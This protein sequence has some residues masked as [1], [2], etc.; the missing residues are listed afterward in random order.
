MTMSS[1]SAIRVADHCAG[2]VTQDVGT[3][4]GVVGVADVLVV[5]DG[6]VVDAG[7]ADVVVEVVG[8]PDPPVD[9]AQP[10]RTAP[11]M[12]RASPAAHT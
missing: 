5:E 10:D 9:P 4:V 11:A 7:G 2:G 3:V 12:A 6:A 8:E 1:C